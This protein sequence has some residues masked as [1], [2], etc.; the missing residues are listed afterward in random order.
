MIQT[1]RNPGA[2]RGR[3]GK[4]HGPG[5]FEMPVDAMDTADTAEDGTRLMRLNARRTGAKTG[6]PERCRLALDVER[7]PA[8]K[9]A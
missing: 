5:G 2:N 9:T 6:E 3:V 4:G 1:T 7:Q 8:R